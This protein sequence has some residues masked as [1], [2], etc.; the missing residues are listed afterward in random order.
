MAHG[1]PFSLS[2]TLFHHLSNGD[3]L[4]RV[5]QRNPGGQGSEGDI[6]GEREEGKGRG[7]QKD[8]GGLVHVI[9][10]SGRS[11]D[12]RTDLPTRDPSEEL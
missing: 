10:A 4:A 11:K 5:L 7:R 12:C 2:Q 1:E 6:E 8:F 9:V 3:V